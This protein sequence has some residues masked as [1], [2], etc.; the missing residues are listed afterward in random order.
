MVKFQL[1][2]SLLILN[3]KKIQPGL[4]MACRHIMKERD[5]MKREKDEVRLREADRD[6]TYLQREG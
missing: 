5:R 1:L 3:N 2:L 4:K 6:R